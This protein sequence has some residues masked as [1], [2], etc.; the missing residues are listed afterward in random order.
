MA[1]FARRELLAG[2]VAAGACATGPALAAS[3]AARLALSTVIP[4]P[5]VRDL[6][7][8]SRTVVLHD[9]SGIAIGGYDPVAYFT[10]G[11][12]VGGKPEHEFSENGV[13]WRFSS[14]ANMAAFRDAPEA[15]RPAFGGYD[16]VAAAEGVVVETAPQ[17][18][19]IIDDSLLLF[20]TA[21]NRSRVASEPDLLARAHASWP[22]LERQ[23]TR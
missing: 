20:R 6:P 2:L 19:L 15:Y 16:P 17:N 5:E 12:A 22:R 8:V 11:T 1:A 7:A 4:V 3:S 18:F 10:S 23:L 14:A 9:R 21:A 13:A